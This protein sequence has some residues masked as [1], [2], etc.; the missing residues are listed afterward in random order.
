MEISPGSIAAVDHEQKAAH[1]LELLLTTPDAEQSAKIRRTELAPGAWGAGVDAFVLSNVLTEA[2]C[3]ALVARS[4]RLGYSFWDPD[5]RRADFRSA[6]TVEFEQRAFSARLWARV[7]PH[8]TAAVELAQ[9]QPQWETELTG[10]WEA[11]GVNHHHLFARYR[12]GGHFSPHTDGYVV[13][14]LNRRSL[15][16]ALVYLN[17]CE[18]GGRTRLLR[19]SEWQPFEKDEKGRF[20]APE[21]SVV[22]DAEVVAGDVLFFYQTVVHEGEPVAEGHEKYIIRTDLMF[23]RAPRICTAPADL[24]AFALM[25]EAELLEATDAAAAAVLFRRCAR[26]SPALCDLYGW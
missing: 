3:G 21:S 15:Y 23:D 10:R 11:A 13:E 20:R 9:G 17:R 25:Q 4:E 1:E 6:H 14:T 18:R 16:S 8:V 19:L 7:A 2:E 24:E 26:L 5:E 22:A 12:G